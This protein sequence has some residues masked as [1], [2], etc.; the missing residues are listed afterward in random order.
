MWLY[1]GL[2]VDGEWVG[3]VSGQFLV[4]FPKAVLESKKSVEA[5]QEP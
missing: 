1:R 2:Q 3:A 5:S 4:G